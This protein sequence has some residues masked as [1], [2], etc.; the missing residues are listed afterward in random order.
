MTK[1]R[2]NNTVLSCDSPAAVVNH[3]IVTI[4]LYLWLKYTHMGLEPVSRSTIS[5]TNA[6]TK[7]KSISHNLCTIRLVRNEKPGYHC[8][9]LDGEV[10]EWYWHRLPS[11]S[12]RSG[13]KAPDVQLYTRTAFCLKHEPTRLMLIVS[14]YY[15]YRWYITFCIMII[16]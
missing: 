3:V 11:S 12:Q 4:Q 10:S 7:W 9:Y 16:T 6:G 5:N 15:Y 1:K 8:K 2:P 13:F 14:S